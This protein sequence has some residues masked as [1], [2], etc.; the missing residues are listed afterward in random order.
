MVKYTYDAW[1]KVLSTTGSLASTLGTVQPFR[2]RGY[3][4]DVE[5]G[6]YYLRSRYYRP[7]LYR[8]VNADALINPNLFGYCGNNPICRVDSSGCDW[9]SFWEEVG[10]FFTNLFRDIR[11]SNE[12]IVMNQAKVNYQLGE[13]IYSAVVGAADCVKKWLN[14]YAAPMVLQIGDSINS[15][16]VRVGDWFKH[17][18]EEC[19]KANQTSIQLGTVMEYNFFVNLTHA[20][21][22]F[23]DKYDIFGKWVGKGLE[24]VGI[25]SIVKKLVSK[26]PDFSFLSKTGSLLFLEWETIVYIMKDAKPI[27]IILEE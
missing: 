11:E 3:V 19:M 21:S 25:S 12:I 22:D 2:Y 6:L 13:N 17:E 8:F 27:N 24:I 7:E 26:F 16:F 10:Q 5:T 23:T 9:S 4:Y 1:G 20:Y 14:N 15:V 18:W